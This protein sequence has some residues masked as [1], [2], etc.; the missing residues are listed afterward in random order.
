M[1]GIADVKKVSPPQLSKLRSDCALT[2]AHIAAKDYGDFS[3]R[4]RL[5]HRTSH[6]L[7]E[8]VVVDFLPAAH[9]LA[10]MGQEHLVLVTRLRLTCETLPQIVGFRHFASGSEDHGVKLPAI[11]VLE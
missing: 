2:D 3:L 8:V 5:L 10:N 7:Y 4:V 6:P 1:L 9:N 11:G